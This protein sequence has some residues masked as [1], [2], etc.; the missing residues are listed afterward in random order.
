[1]NFNND[2]C[3]W[4]RDLQKY[5]SENPIKLPENWRHFSSD[6]PPWNKGQK[7]IVKDSLETRNK[8][9]LAKLGKK[10]G[11]YL[12]S[13]KWDPDTKEARCQAYKK[14]WTPERRAALVERNKKRSK[15]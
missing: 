7:G 15:Q 1:M 3:E 14:A 4:V 13:K 10:R 12:T 8:K 11:P 5:C 6:L 2:D 9:R